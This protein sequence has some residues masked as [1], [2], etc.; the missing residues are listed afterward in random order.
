LRIN[1]TAEDYFIRS[2]AARVRVLNFGTLFQDKVQYIKLF[3][4]P[5]FYPPSGLPAV[6]KA[7]SVAN[8]HRGCMDVFLSFKIDSRLRGKN[9]HC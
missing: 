5:F 3:L 8:F 1:L 7:D 6:G 4:V 9:S 2:P